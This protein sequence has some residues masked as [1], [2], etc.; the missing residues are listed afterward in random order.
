[1]NWRKSHKKNFTGKEI[2]AKTLQAKLK[3]CSLQRYRNKFEEK[4]T[5]MPF[6]EKM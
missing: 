1:M 3:T 4:Q 5:C 6:L 2:Y